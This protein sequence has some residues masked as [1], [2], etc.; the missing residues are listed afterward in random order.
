MESSNAA[1]V[2]LMAASSIRHLN[3][4]INMQILVYSYVIIQ[5]LGN[6]F[7]TTHVPNVYYM[8]KVAGKK[9]GPSN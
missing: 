1:S 4:Q 3:N 5:L 9:L 2:L 8:C 6:E 7:T